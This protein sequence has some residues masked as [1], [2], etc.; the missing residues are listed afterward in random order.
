[1]TKKDFEAIAEVMR[2]ARRQLDCDPGC[3]D[4]M[5]YISRG[6]ADVCA[7]NNGRFD[8]ARFLRACLR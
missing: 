2:D 1:M 5:D 3:V 8:R 4:A 7:E 6:L